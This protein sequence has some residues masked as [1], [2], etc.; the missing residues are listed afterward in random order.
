MAFKDLKTKP[1]ILIGVLSP[2]IL[3]LALGGVAVY[4]INSMLQTS[5]WVSHTYDVLAEASAVVGS[6]VDMETGMRGYLLAGKEGFLDPY[7]GGEKATYTQIDKLKNTVSDN[8]GQVNRLEEVEKTLKEWQANVTEP[9]I[10]LRR[11]IGD[12]K[13]MNDMAALVGEARGKVFFDKFRG[14]IATFIGREQELL[15]KRRADF[16][17]AQTAVGENFELVNQTMGWVDHTHKVLAAAEELLANVVDMETGMRGYLL[18]GEEEFLE[19]Y[20]GGKARFADG[21]AELQQTVSDNPPQ[22]ERLKEMQQLINDWDG[23]VVAQALR[24]RRQANSGLSTLEDVDAFVSQKLGK[25]YIDGFR[26]KIAEFSGIERELMVTRQQSAAEAEGKVSGDLV[27]MK[28]NEAWVTHTY[29]VIA[30]ANDILSA[31]VDMETGMRGYLLAGKEDFLDPYNNGRATF[32]KLVDGLMETVSD[33]PAQV[34]LLKEIDTTIHDWEVNVT[35]PTID[36][37]RQIGDAK[38]MDDMADLVGEA[39]GKV[40]FDKFRQIIGDFQAEEEELMNV[41]KQ[42]AEDMEG[43]AYTMIA[44]CIL[45]AIAI[46]VIIA[47]VIGGAIAN[48]IADMTGSMRDLAAGNKSIDIPGQGRGDEIGDMAG[49]VQVFKENMIKADQLAEAQK[50]EEEA[51]EKERVRVNKL[52][53]DFERTMVTVLDSLGEANRSMSRVSDQVQTSA[54]NTKHE[55]TNVAAAAEQASRNVET[56]AS[57]AEELSSSINEISRQVSDAN[58]VSSEAVSAADETSAQIRVLEDNVLKIGE[59]VDLIN[60]IAAQT[61]LLALNATIEAARAGDAGK[62]FAVVASEVKNL[63]NQTGRAT[64]EIATQINQVQKSTQEAVQSIEG[65]TTVIR[66]ISEISGSISA[67]VEQQGAATN[68]IARN[69]EEAAT[70]TQSVSNSIND[71]LAS[72]EQSS[73][74]ANEIAGA[75]DGLATQSTTLQD[76]VAAFLKGVQ[77]GAGEATDLLEWDPDHETG[78]AQIDREHRA[79]FD[80][81]NAIYRK[82][83]SGHQ[84]QVSGAALD[85]SRSR[86]EAHFVSEEN[87]MAQHGYAGL[88]SHRAEHAEFLGRFDELH[89]AFRKGQVQRELE[90]LSFL[91]SWWT[92]HME[93]EDARLATFAKQQSGSHIRLAS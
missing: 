5:K 48:P 56:V 41:R 61:N 49:A 68:E 13:T 74:A 34:E 89:E 80:E 70:G 66:N 19:P 53:K 35:K 23:K 92:R 52:I 29:K 15:D 38:T 14:Q 93:G 64:D 72:A 37:R 12:A 88:D 3:L 85:Q 73:A 59:I 50:A 86:Y 4:S 21:I 9:T 62:G 84:D 39:R 6:A 10:A 47:W 8:P 90:V 51:K 71:V 43:F 22:V 11:S 28:D 65:I 69:V 17:A 77:Q 1:K 44:V 7:K 60:D 67:A 26:A 55:S 57:A 54:E 82:V 58:S 78:I 20:N 25:Q 30:K 46:G 81:M 2:L 24:L 33:N 32:H 18:A 76:R 45:A 31:A 40:Y 75:S 27:T 83:Q 87:Y 79:L 36:L 16:E 42:A 91:G 63:A